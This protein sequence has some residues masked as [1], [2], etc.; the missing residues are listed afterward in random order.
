MIAGKKLR[1]GLKGKWDKWGMRKKVLKRGQKKG[2]RLKIINAY[3]ITYFL[4]V[5]EHLL[6]VR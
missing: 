4:L 1:K 2:I 6:K 5:D 3:T